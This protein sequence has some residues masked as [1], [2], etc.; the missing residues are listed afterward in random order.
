VPEV[1]LSGHHG[2]IDRWRRDESLRRTARRRPDLIAALD[3][4]R[5]DRADLAVLEQ[6][7]VTPG[8]GCAISPG[9]THLAD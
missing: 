9:P 3:P 5:L 6:E 8:S 4:A 7:G 2:A 1:L